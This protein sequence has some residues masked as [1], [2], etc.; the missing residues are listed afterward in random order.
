MCTYIFFPPLP[1]LSGGMAVLLDTAMYL[2]EAGFE[3][4]LVVR[5]PTPQLSVLA[6]GVPVLLWEQMRLAAGDIWLTPE[7]WPNALAPGLA[8]RA[9]CLVYVQN[10]AFAHGK[11]PP[12]VR[13]EQLPVEFLAVS[14]PVAWFMEQTIGVN[15]PILRPGINRQRFYPPE[16]DPA[17]PLR[18]PLRI[19]FMPRKNKSMATQI[20]AIFD[21]RSPRHGIPTE[22]VEIHGLPPDGVAAAL[23]SSHIFLATGFPEGLGLPPLEAMAC[24]C[25]VAGFAGFGGWDYLRQALPEAFPGRFTPWWPL[26]AAAEMSWENNAFVTADADNLAAALALE[27]AACLLRDGGEHLSNLRSQGQRTADAYS[28]GRHRETVCHFWQTLMP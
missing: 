17:A 12:G 15:P 18:E 7:G 19:A 27:H 8:A 24:G 16:R 5:E 4:S 3:V 10:W 6:P 13:W 26:R 28:T 14:Q 1:L 25:L 23:R 2:R 22:W 9:S 11:L 21:A 20:R